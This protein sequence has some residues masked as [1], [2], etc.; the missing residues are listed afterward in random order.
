MLRRAGRGY[1]RRAVDEFLARCAA[2][3]ADRAADVPGLPPPASGDLPRLDAGDVR[4]VRFPVV[5]GGYDMAEVDAL[6]TRVAKVLP[7]VSDRPGW[8]GDAPA[9]AVGE[10]LH[11]R[12]SAQGY[13]AEQV[14][15][16]LTRCAHTLGPR[17]SEVPEL[18]GLLRR[19]RT[20]DPVRAR[21][22]ETVQFRVRLGGVSVEQVDALLDRVAGALGR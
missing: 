16:F 11:L 14:L 4:D 7:A 6:L 8:G 3:L 22:V 1:S 2:S 12:R 18:A 9:S 17:V 20:G 13:D 19:P 5:V 21:D 15:A 10:P